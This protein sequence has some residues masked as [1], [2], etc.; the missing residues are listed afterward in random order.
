MN[1]KKLIISTV[2]AVATFLILI[3]GASFA[4]FTVG[5]S[6]DFET[7]NISVEAESVGSV[8]LVQGDNISIDLTAADMMEKESDV[9]YYGTSNGKTTTETEEKIATATVTGDGRYNCSYTLNMDDNSNSMYDIF[10]V[11][12]EKSAGQIILT[13]NGVNYD[14]NNSGMFPKTISGTLNGITKNNP[15]YLTAKLKI[16]NSSTI[17]Q[18]A[19]AGSNITITF[20]VSEFNCNATSNYLD[21]V[22]YVDG[23]IVS[24]NGKDTE[25]TNR[26]RTDYIYLEAGT[27]EIS[28]LQ[29]AF[30]TVYHTYSANDGT[31]WIERILFTK[32]LNSDY[33]KSVFT[34]PS[35]VYV[36]IVF[37][38]TDESGTTL[39]ASNIANYV[40]TLVKIS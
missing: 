15:K 22:T 26:V 24:N 28:S 30:A 3:V 4:Y 38:A 17:D 39:K 34:I 23:S 18:S 1:N 8:A 37:R 16:V 9:T 11:M 13:V 6:N 21:N 27:Y 20:N 33:Y 10:Q 29:P 36:R 40:P 19:L 32:T 35:N 5:T 2:I 31:G 7:R 14:F 12:D 25:G